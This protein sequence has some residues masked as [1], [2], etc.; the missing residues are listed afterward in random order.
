MKKIINEIITRLKNIENK[1]D[2]TDKISEYIDKNYERYIEEDEINNIENKIRDL[3]YSVKVNAEFDYDYEKIHKDDIV[4]FKDGCMYFGETKL[5]AYWYKE[6]MTEKEIED[7]CSEYQ[8]VWWDL[9]YRKVTYP[10]LEE[11]HELSFWEKYFSKAEIQNMEKALECDETEDTHLFRELYKKGSY[12]TEY[13]LRDVYPDKIN[14]VIDATELKKENN[15]EYT[16][17][18]A[19]ELKNGEICKVL[20]YLNKN[21]EYCGAKALSDK[22]F[23]WFTKRDTKLLENYI[24]S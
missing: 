20:L 8:K 22:G 19:I 17:E 18:V 23:P 11:W 12:V 13:Q 15:G 10:L 1:L 2:V 7:K 14:K 6:D 9:E 4:T 24:K 3:L 21:K 5:P 16:S